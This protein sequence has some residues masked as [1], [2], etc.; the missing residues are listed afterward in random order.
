MV[1]REVVMVPYERVNVDIVGPMPRSRIG[2]RF[3]L[4][5]IDVSSRWP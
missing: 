4:T 2:F 3:I 5:Y 1:A